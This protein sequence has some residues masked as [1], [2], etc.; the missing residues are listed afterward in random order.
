MKLDR[1]H[2]SSYGHFRDREWDF[3]S[4]GARGGLHLLH[5]ANASGKSTFL[6][7][8]SDLLY[9]FEKKTDFTQ[10][11]GD[12]NTTE[13]SAHLSFDDST[14][15]EVKRAGGRFLGPDGSPL[16]KADWLARLGNLSRGDFRTFFALH[17][18]DLRSGGKRLAENDETLSR[19]IFSASLGGARVLSRLQAMREES[20]TLFKKGGRSQGIYQTL[21][22]I[23]KAKSELKKEIISPAEVKKSRDLYREAQER[24]ETIRD[25]LAKVLGEIE[26]LEC[27]TRH[28]PE[29]R[30]RLT[31]SAERETLNTDRAALSPT[32]L[33][34]SLSLMQEIETQT[35]R[36]SDL[37]G[38]KEN[39]E[40]S[41]QALAIPKSLPEVEHEITYLSRNFERYN[42]ASEQIDGLREELDDL[43]RQI[44]NSELSSNQASNPQEDLS[45]LMHLSEDLHQD[46]TRAEDAATE[47][48]RL[49]AELTELHRQHANAKRDQLDLQEIQREKRQLERL[50]S[51]GDAI[52]Q[53][54]QKRLGLEE[55]ISLAA[56]RCGFAGSITPDEILAL[57]PAPTQE[58][59]TDFCERQDEI[60]KQISDQDAEQKRLQAD[61]LDARDDARR[62]SSS[63]GLPAG[64]AQQLRDAGL[65]RDKLLSELYQKL[66]IGH[67]A[68]DE[69]LTASEEAVKTVDALHEARFTHSTQIPRLDASEQKVQKTEEKLGTLAKNRE[70]LLAQQTKLLTDWQALWSAFP[71]DPGPILSKRDWSPGY[72]DLVKKS[73]E[74]LQ[75]D[76]RNRAHRQEVASHLA[77]P[78]ESEDLVNTS[79]FLLERLQEVQKQEAIAIELQGSLKQWEE[80]L[81]YRDEACAEAKRRDAEATKQFRK[82]QALWADSGALERF[83][84]EATPQEIKTQAANSQIIGKL[85]GSYR[86][87]KRRIASLEKLMTDFER[88]ASEVREGLELGETSVTDLV[89]QGEAVLANSI[90][91]REIAENLALKE[92]EVARQ[93]AACKA[94]A[95]KL[96]A[97]ASEISIGSI[98]D[99]SRFL[100]DEEKRHRIDEAIRTIDRSFA[101]ASQRLTKEELFE[102]LGAHDEA[103][104]GLALKEQI[105]Q[106][107]L[108]DEDLKTAYQKEHDARGHL[109]AIETEDRRS[110]EY[111]QHLQNEL[112][113]LET[114]LERYLTLQQAIVFLEGSIEAFHTENQSPVL[115]R[116]GGF[117]HQLTNGTFSGLQTRFDEAGNSQLTAARADGR[118]MLI[119]ELSEGT[120]DQ[121]FLSL[122]LALLESHAETFES[123]PLFLDDILMTYDDERAAATLRVLGDMSSQI[124]VFLLTHHEHLVDLAKTELAGGS[125]QLHRLSELAD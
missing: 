113:L 72:L 52:A 16:A 89:R 61:L 56:I 118:S 117:F 41:L 65:I 46:K 7:S 81:R 19:T 26:T 109:N 43:Q 91:H 38:E 58:S 119:H 47:L 28:L 40:T 31:L 13:V 23:E 18:E 69:E 106:R 67:Q 90:R 70:Q 9:G 1:F 115:N 37:K 83:G 42:E 21:V 10:A 5:G 66:R 78:S 79:E 17:S 125:Y 24:A 39:T 48:K 59:I 116:A 71:V 101:T 29:W 103:S 12:G 22:N 100:P 32:Q 96:S 73:R 97:I 25:E 87:L 98:E 123:M 121:L 122:R 6:R 64:S 34:D 111:R 102:L 95:D 124:Q 85:Q 63:T 80:T 108:L 86:D 11:L 68:N 88:K 55:E 120:Q 75:L 30:E 93:T 35:A 3:T 53:D 62:L 4:P 14:S 94:L 57:P 105:T 114:Q 33:R 15:L 45:S 77:L 50:V 112:S 8:I 36:L 2:L 84:S 92:Q 104:L 44:E 20:D 51:A 82:T 49:R 110:N 54:E 99:L 74:L 107:Q 60:D 27:L 76:Q